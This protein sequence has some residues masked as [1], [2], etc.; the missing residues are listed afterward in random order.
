MVHLRGRT[1]L[2]P[3]P[4][5]PIP[6]PDWLILNPR[7]HA[8]VMP[9]R[10]L[11]PFVRYNEEIARHLPHLPSPEPESEDDEIVIIRHVL[12]PRRPRPPPLPPPP[13]PPLPE[14]ELF[15]WCGWCRRPLWVGWILPC[16]H[17]I[18]DKCYLKDTGKLT[19]DEI[20]EPRL[21]FSQDCPTCLSTFLSQIVWLND[22]WI[23]QPKQEV[24]RYRAW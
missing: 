12:P 15:L 22:R 19:E 9:S 3:P 20:K 5:P 8:K 16:G 17:A 23:W 24:S 7:F 11:L 21:D 18:D 1:P 2:P 4:Q 13:P 14:S 10:A 6:Y